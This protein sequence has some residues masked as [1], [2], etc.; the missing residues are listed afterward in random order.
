MLQLLS[1]I[2]GDDINGIGI[3]P[4]FELDLYGQEAIPL[5]L[6]ATDFTNFAENTA[7]YS[8]VF[9]LP[10]TKNNNIFFN[11]IYEATTDCDFNPH[12]I[13]N[14]VVKENTIDIFKGY[15]QLTEIN[16]NE[17]GIIYS[18]VLY[19][20]AVNIKD[21]LSAK[22]FRDLDI[23]ELTHTFSK[24]N[25]IASWTTGLPLSAPLPA[26]TF[27]GTPG[28]TTATCIKYP[29]VKWSNESWFN[30][31]TNVITF[32]YFYDVFRP[33]LTVKYL[34]LSIFRDIGYTI[35]SNFF[36]TTAFTKLFTD[37]NRGWGPSG[38]GHSATFEVNRAN[39]ELYPATGTPTVIRQNL[40]YNPNTYGVINGANFYNTST[41]KFT[42][43]GLNLGFTIYIQIKTS[44]PF[45]PTIFI[46]LYKNNVLVNNIYN[47][48]TPSGTN[49]STTTYVNPPANGDV[50][51]VR[52]SNTSDFSIL[53]T[54]RGIIFAVNTTTQFMQDTF[55]FDKGDTNQW[56]WIKSIIDCFNLLIMPDVNN[57][58]NVIIEPY[59]DWIDKG[60]VR[61]WTNK[62]DVKD[63]KLYPIGNLSKILTF[64]HKEDTPDWQTVNFNYPNTWRYPY[65]Q[66]NAIDIFSK[67]NTLKETKLSS[68]MYSRVLNDL[69]IIP[70]IVALSDASIGDVNLPISNLG[71]NWPN[72]WRLLY[73]NGVKT[74]APYT[75][76]TYQFSAESTYLLFSP[77][78]DVPML[79]TSVS[80]DF[81]VVNYDGIGTVLN[82]L[83]NQYWSRYVDELYHKDTRVLKLAIYLTADDMRDFAFNDVIILKNKKYRCSKID[84]RAGSLSKAEFITIKDL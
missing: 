57:A 30:P 1:Y 44:S 60:A 64:R 12:K 66:T 80:T 58:S 63:I 15:L 26:D 51:E 46:G 33:W 83:Y 25:L 31:A 6:S 4:I 10:G 37:A 5:T 65:V 21:L 68:T 72:N 38:N 28:A 13:T 2:Q 77:V 20:N 70:S 69:M 41:Y 56:D 8:Q 84:Y 82:S 7:S 45:T 39:T 59:N 62:I 42:A 75:Y 55:I 67:Q 73:D 54:S 27:A 43:S 50:F 32:P 19:S 53:G 48:A 3:T 23:S 78:S 40:I 61:N 16:N 71:A 22:V 24:A 81:G 52:V 35:T 11:H 49:I 76:T 34:F 17:G 36:N 14:I 9:K 47:A 29:F 79:S 74:I 18:V